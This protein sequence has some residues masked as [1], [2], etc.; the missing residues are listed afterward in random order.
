[1]NNIKL[2]SIDILEKSFQVEYKGYDAQ[3]VDAFLDIIVE[4]YNCFEKNTSKYKNEIDSLNIK[5]NELETKIE[6]LRAQLDLTRQEKEELAEKGLR[7]AD[8]VKRLSSLENKIN[9]K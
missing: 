8:L 1:M 4:D 9:N 7:N 5:V 2:K 6:A 3:E